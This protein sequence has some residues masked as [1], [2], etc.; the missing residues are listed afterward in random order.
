MVKLDKVAGERET[1]SG[2]LLCDFA[3]R[4][5]IELVE[6]PIELALRNPDALVDD[7]DPN[8]P[9]VERALI[10]GEPADVHVDH[11]AL[12]RELDRIRKEVEEDLL[13]ASFVEANCG[14]VQ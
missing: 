12:R 14:N 8:R 3:G 5:L 2:S 7:V 10:S 1:E 9:G 11:S 6:N 4:A 13:E